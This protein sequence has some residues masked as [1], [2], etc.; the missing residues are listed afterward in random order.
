VIKGSGVP[1]SSAHVHLG[2]RRT[3]AAFLLKGPAG[4]KKF[5]PM[6]LNH[7]GRNNDQIYRLAQE[8]AA[9]H[10]LSASFVDRYFGSIVD[11]FR[12]FSVFLEENWR[13]EFRGVKWGHDLLQD[14]GATWICCCD[15]D[16]GVV[17]DGCLGDLRKV[18]GLI[19]V[20][21]EFPLP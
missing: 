19:T 5:A 13:I 3:T 9:Q 7:L 1:A 15:L 18:G 10:R 21:V 11:Y 14:F 17:S 6:R 8:S 20:A 16:V 4:G 12:V 2:E